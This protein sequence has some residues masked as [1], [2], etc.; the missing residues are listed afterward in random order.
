M[1]DTSE[2]RDAVPRGED[3][4]TNPIDRF[5]DR[6]LCQLGG[7]KMNK[8]KHTDLDGLPKTKESV[9]SHERF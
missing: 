6:D 9:I 5:V 8:N 7:K 3:E 1:R 2:N 4:P